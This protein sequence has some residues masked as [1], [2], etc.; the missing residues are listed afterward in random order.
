MRE[1]LSRVWKKEEGFSLIELIIVIAI[2]AIIA[3][4]AVPNLVENL[5]NSREG[6]DKTSAKMV[7]DAVIQEIALKE[8]DSA[9]MAAFDEDA[10][11]AEVQ[12]VFAAFA[13]P[14]VANAGDGSAFEDNVVKKLN[15]GIPEIK[16][17]PNA[18]F[19][20]TVII[21]GTDV[22]VIVSVDDGTDTHIVFPEPAAPA[23]DNI[24]FD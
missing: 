20:A 15:N 19:E 7:A 23:A 9:E 6:V 24:Y 14:Q 2:L 8:Y 3:A 17:I 11:A 12:L 4:I 22:T 21:D 13:N 5:N 18:H 10:G 1:L 16:R